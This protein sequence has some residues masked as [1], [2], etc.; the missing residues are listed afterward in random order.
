MNIFNVRKMSCLWLNLTKIITY[1]HYVDKYSIQ[2]NN[3]KCAIDYNILFSPDPKSCSSQSIIW[4]ICHL[5]L[6]HELDRQDASH[7]CFS[8]SITANK[9]R[10]TITF[11]SLA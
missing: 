8:N 2:A 7:C 10:M 9:D 1:R 3:K 5:Q 11:T 4:T 6:Q